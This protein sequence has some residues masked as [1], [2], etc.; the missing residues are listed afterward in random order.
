MVVDASAVPEAAS[1]APHLPPFDHADLLRQAADAHWRLVGDDGETVGRCSLWWRRTPSLAGR[2]AGLIGHYAAR[3][4]L[5]GHRLLWH[6]CGE[7]AARGCALAVGPMDGSTWHRYRLIIDRGREPTFFLEPD[8]PDDWPRHFLESGFTPL[9]HYRSAV[10]TDPGRSDPRMAEVAQRLVGQG[11]RIRALDPSAFEDELRRIH[12]VAVSS[13]R[14][15]FLCT[16]LGEAE[17]IAHYRPLRPHVRPELVLIAEKQGA[18]IGFIFGIPDLLQARRGPRIDT[19]V[20][21]TMAVLPGHGGAG[22]GGLLMARCQE[23]ARELGYTRA[24]HALMHEGSHS[25]RISRHYARTIR[26]YALFAR[27]LSP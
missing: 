24:I 11:V 2:R 17:F 5:T 8:N 1:D 12:A 16:P 21:K 14:H 18:P 23:T 27:T 10:N 4:A 13:F 22:L 3:D 20:I 6:G 9:A 7:L 26:R 25:G 15:N 19:V